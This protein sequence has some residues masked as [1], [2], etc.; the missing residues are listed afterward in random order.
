MPLKEHGFPAKLKSICRI[1]DIKKGRFE[2]LKLI[3]INYENYYCNIEHEYD[4]IKQM[5]YRMQLRSGWGAF[6]IC[7]TCMVKM[8]P[9]LEANI[10]DR[11]TNIPKTILEPGEQ[12]TRT[13]FKWGDKVDWLINLLADRCNVKYANDNPTCHSCNKSCCIVSVIQ[14]S[15]TSN[16]IIMCAVC[17]YRFN[18]LF[19]NTCGYNYNY[20]NDSAT[21][22]PI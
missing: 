18:T 4:S 20:D 5:S 7:S 17:M 2:K 14:D 13:D 10:N 16:E 8:L 21:P 3:P 9:Q 22:E 15:D 6:D 19:T 1:T 11:P 12:F